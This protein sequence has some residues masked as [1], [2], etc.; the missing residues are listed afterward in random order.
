MQ[1]GS[2]ILHLHVV[3][4]HDPSTFRATVHWV[5]QMVEMKMQPSEETVAAC[6][7]ACSKS[8]DPST[9]AAGLK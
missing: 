1:I 5:A 6:V 9:A 8:G 2:Q 3:L 7:A 4:F